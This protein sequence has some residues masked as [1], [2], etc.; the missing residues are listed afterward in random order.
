[1]LKRGTLWSVNSS[2]ISPAL[3][4]N[5]KVLLSYLLPKLMETQQK[6]QMQ[7]RKEEK[8][9]MMGFY[10]THLMHRN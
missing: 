7:K 6:L 10:I 2:Q 4:N 1:M 9:Q 8:T 5:A 3:L